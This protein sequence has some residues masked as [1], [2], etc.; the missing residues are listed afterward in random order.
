MT[1]ATKEFMECTD[2]IMKI[3]EMFEQDNPD[4]DEIERILQ[5]EICPV[6]CSD[7]HKAMCMFLAFH[8]TLHEPEFME[9]IY[10]D[11]FKYIDQNNLLK[12]GVLFNTSL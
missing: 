12:E 9:V 11:V 7:I 2:K 4:H 10:L 5:D 6:I 8:E 3:Y 1:E